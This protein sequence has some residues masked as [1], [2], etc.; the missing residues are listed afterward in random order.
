M[1]VKKL[2]TILFL[3]ITAYLSFPVA[4]HAY[5]DPGSSSYVFQILIAGFFGLLYTLKKFWKQISSFMAE[6]FS[7]IRKK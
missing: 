4:T 2:S 1:R 7:K 6:L 5:L 3:L